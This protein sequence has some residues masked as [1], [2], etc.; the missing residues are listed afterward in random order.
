VSFAPGNEGWG[1]FSIQHAV[2]RT[3]R[4]SAALLDAVS[5]PQPGD[6]YWAAPPETSFLDAAEREPGRLRIGFITGGINVPNI[7]PECAAAVR[8][9]A[10]LCESLGHHVFEAQLGW[11]YARVQIAA[12]LI[13]ASSLAATIDNEG[14]RRGRAVAEGEVEPSTWA[15]Y[16]HG[17]TIAASTYV[18]ALQTAH[19]FGRAA[20]RSFADFDILLTSTLG[21]PAP[22]VGWLSGGGPAEAYAHRLFSFMPNTQPFNVSGQPAI[23][24]PLAVSE[25]GLPI[26][27]QFVAPAGEEG[28]LLR[29]A[30]QLEQARPW[31][32]RRPPSTAGQG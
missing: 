29:L 20:A 9:A 24:L 27:L 1:G 6:P 28:L 8:D 3:V 2:S 32:A 21:M 22:P 10:H 13:V 12:G 18:Q 11:D 17:K 26:G 16:Q 23:S 30:G 15:F 5:R 4:D 7:D 14:L 31:A 25:A 19:A